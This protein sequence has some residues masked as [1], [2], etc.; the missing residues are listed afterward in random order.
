M[1]QGRSA[2]SGTLWMRRIRR[3]RPTADAVVASMEASLQGVR[4]HGIHRRGARQR[5]G[6]HGLASWAWRGW[7]PR[8]TATVATGSARVCSGEGAEDEGESR[9]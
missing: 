3:R 1:R 8:R 7:W 9:E 2:A 4:A 5:G 6:A